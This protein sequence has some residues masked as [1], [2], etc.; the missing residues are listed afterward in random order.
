MFLLATSCPPVTGPLPLP[1][2]E[3]GDVVLR[4]SRRTPASIL[5]PPS[6]SLNPI[7]SALNFVDVDG[8]HREQRDEHRHE[9]R[10]QVGV[11]NDPRLV[12]HVLFVLLGELVVAS[13]D[14]LS[15]SLR[16]YA[17]SASAPPLPRPP[18]RGHVVA[19][20]RRNVRLQQLL[21][22]A[23]AHAGLDRHD[24]FDDQLLCATSISGELLQLVR[25]RQPDAV[26]EEHA[27]ERRDERAGDAVTDLLRV[28]RGAP[29]SPS[30]R[31]PRR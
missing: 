8:R 30:G 22:H 26:G 1:L 24:P 6:A 31:T 15:T 14:M 29:S 27:P 12:V 9:Q 4:R 23:G 10:E 16:R 2:P 20:R 19:L 13:V 11:G 5:P 21:D 3:I 25:H 17:A 28:R 18:R 7:A